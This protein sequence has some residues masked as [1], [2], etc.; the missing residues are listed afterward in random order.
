MILYTKINNTVIKLA[1]LQSLPEVVISWQQANEFLRIVTGSEKSQVSS[2]LSRMCETL[3]CEES[4]WPVLIPEQSRDYIVKSKK[5]ELHEAILNNLEYFSLWLENRKFLDSLQS[6]RVDT[7]KIRNISYQRS[8]SFSSKWDDQQ[9]IVYSTCRT[10]T[11]RLTITSGLNFLVMPKETRKCILA[12]FSDSTIYSIDF[13]S[14]EPRVALWAASESVSREDVYEEVMEMCEIEKR[15]VAKLATLS[16]LY[17]A[18]VHRLAKTVGSQKKAKQLIE[19]V[20]RYF[21]VDSFE[22]R[23]EEAASEKGIVKNF[24]GRPLQEAT[25]N[26]RLRLNHF[27]QSTAA[28][29]AVLMFSRLCAD[30]SSVRPLLVIH[31]ALIVEVDKSDDSKFL[32]ACKDIH[33]EGFWFPTKT[34]T[35]DI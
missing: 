26:R 10:A 8:G 3:R 20:S 32:K 12:D 21:G 9:K 5:E 18:G 24:F 2:Q 6:F 22:G 35:L 33:H 16:T 4:L 28:E 31:D 30:F 15:E 14:L 25:V 1:E 13:T 11:G 23:L 17:G 19:R 7:E 27:I 34:E 29:L